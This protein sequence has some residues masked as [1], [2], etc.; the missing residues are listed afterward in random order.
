ML[1]I[2]RGAD[3]TFG[4]QDTDAIQVRI[5]AQAAVDVPLPASSRMGLLEGKLA[6]PPG[7]ARQ[8]ASVIEFELLPIRKLALSRFTQGAPSAVA[9]I[10]CH[11][12]GSS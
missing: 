12:L 10:R 3:E 8:G 4:T 9:L 5:R 1:K 7:A 2:L 11:V 6:W